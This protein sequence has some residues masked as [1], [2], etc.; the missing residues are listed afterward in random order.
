MLILD[1]IKNLAEALK[2]KEN[3]D[4]FMGTFFASVFACC[5][6]VRPILNVFS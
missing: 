6:E 3:L 2:S 5:K 1:L 4:F